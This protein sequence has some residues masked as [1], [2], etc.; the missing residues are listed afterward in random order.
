MT[1]HCVHFIK[2]EH[3]NVSLKQYRQ[4][5]KLI[6]NNKL[7]NLLKKAGRS[8]AFINDALPRL[9]KHLIIF[10]PSQ[11]HSHSHPPL[12]S[13]F[14]GWGVARRQ[15]VLAAA[16]WDR[17]Q[18]SPF[19]ACHPLLSI[20]SF[21]ISSSAVLSNKAKNILKKKNI[22]FSVRHPNH[23]S[24][25]NWTMFTSFCSQTFYYTWV[26]Q[27]CLCSRAACVSAHVGVLCLRDCQCVTDSGSYKLFFSGGTKLTVGSSKTKYPGFSLVWFLISLK[28]ITVVFYHVF[29]SHLC[30]A[31]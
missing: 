10:S 23:E 15:R 19:A 9:W 12:K 21:P 18:S 31:Q 24:W 22:R 5:E 8:L 29:H 2:A 27:I 7:Q 11:S 28:L 13:D 25:L 30:I 17:I 4:T 1:A 6:Q 3:K 14:L 16:T 26:H 20:P